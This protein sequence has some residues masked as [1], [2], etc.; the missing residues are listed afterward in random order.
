MAGEQARAFIA[1]ERSAGIPD[2]KIFNKMLDD[3]KFSQGIR[4]ANAD[5]ISNRVFAAGLGL[6]ISSEPV[7]LNAVKK[8]AML[9]QAKEEGPTNAVGSF[10]LGLADIFGGARQGTGYVVDGVSKGINKVAGTNLSTNEYERYTKQFKEAEDW[11]NLRRE[12]SGQSYDVWRLGGQ[13]VGSVPM[14]TAGRTYQ[15]TKVFS[16]A[17]ADVAAQNTAVGAGIGGAS[18]AENSDQRLSNTSWGTVGGAVG[19]A[20]GKKVGDVAVKVRNIAKGRVNQNAAGISG[21]GNKHGVR[22]TVGDISRNPIIQK[23]EVAMEQVPIVGTSSFRQAQH[24]ETKAAANKIVNSF[25]E[26][27]T[28]SE[29][30]GLS[31]LEAAA[32]AGDRNASRIVGLIE[33]SAND[34]SKIIQV[35]A[36]VKAWREATIASKMYDDVAA[37]AKHQSGVVKTTNTSELLSQKIDDE[38]ASLAPDQTMLKDLQQIQARLEDAGVVKDFANMRLLRSQLGDMAENYAAGTSP[39]KSASKFL[40]DLR[41]AVESDIEVYARAGSNELKTAYKRADLFYRNSMK[42]KDTAIARSLKSNKPDEIYDQFIKTGKADR[43]SNFYSNLDM[44]SQAALRYEMAKRALEKATNLS[45]GNFSPAKFAL[46]FE[47]FKEPYGVIFKGR[48]KAE[49]NG[50]V[51]LMRYTERAG[52]YMENPPTGNRTVGI[53]IGGATAINPTLA[54]Q[55]VAASMLAKILFTTSVGKRILLAA[56]DLPAQSNKLRNLLKMAESLNMLIGANLPEKSKE[57]DVKKE[58]NERISNNTSISNLS[59]IPPSQNQSLNERLVEA[60]LISGSNL[61]KQ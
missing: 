59:S 32:S 39:N 46:E 6:K 56:N 29:F 48:D 52:Q 36:E 37:L 45:T 35:G 19:G 27:M 28:D 34:S 26:T 22:T 20:V 41:A 23:T 51:K 24:G 25:K 13:A 30:K 33:Q 47:R 11:H 15:G 49:M 18:F 1:K 58:T 31:K 5:G 38:L 9:K 8:E 42:N 17:G 53:L 16:K 55:T 61:P 10:F 54:T 50:F 14:A 57:K 2:I 7:D 21:L 4:R 60:G 43:A 40:G 3:P 44:K 12:A